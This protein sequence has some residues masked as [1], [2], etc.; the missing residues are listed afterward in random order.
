MSEE[1]GIRVTIHEGRVWIAAEGRYNNGTAMT[2]ADRLERDK[3][4]ARAAFERAKKGLHICRSETLNSAESSGRGYTV[5]SS[6]PE[7]ADD[8]LNS[9]EFKE[10]VK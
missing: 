6:S 7:T 4:I 3:A 8:Y 10:L 1:K 5:Q 9:E 2:F